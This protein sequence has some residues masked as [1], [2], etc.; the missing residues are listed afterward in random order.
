MAPPSLLFPTSGEAKQSP[1]KSR[2]GADEEEFDEGE[3]EDVES[4]D[5]ADDDIDSSTDDEAVEF[6]L[7]DDAD[8]EPG[9]PDEE[10]WW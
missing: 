6:H 3:S 5:D 1:A 10:R 4:E 8:E 2:F 7:D 9:E